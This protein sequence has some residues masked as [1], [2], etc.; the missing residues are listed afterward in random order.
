[1]CY[2][3]LHRLNTLNLCV[4]SLDYFAKKCDA[5]DHNQNYLPQSNFDSDQEL[6]AVNQTVSP[7]YSDVISSTAAVKGSLSFHPPNKFWF[8]RFIL[9]VFFFFNWIQQMNR[10]PQVQAQFKATTIYPNV[11]RAI[12][13][14]ILAMVQ[15]IWSKYAVCHGLQR[16]RIYSISLWTC[17]FRMVRTAYT[18]SRTIKIILVLPTFNC[19]HAKILNGHKI[20][21]TNSWAID[22]LKVKR[23]WI[24]S[25][26]IRVFVHLRGEKISWFTSAH[27][28]WEVAEHFHVVS[29]KCDLMRIVVSWNYLWSSLQICCFFLLYVSSIELFFACAHNRVLFSYC[30]KSVTV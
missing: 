19:R 8:E 30:F 14:W 16:K 12:F 2:C 7:T 18:S 22:T 21:I 4:F 17:T 3:R 24:W 5:V 11:K 27:I 25:K 9:R 23:N 29:L 10:V 28:V 15:H 26:F 1:M 20:S 6:T 13:Q